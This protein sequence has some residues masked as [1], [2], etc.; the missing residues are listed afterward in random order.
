ML[1][2]DFSR[3]GRKRRISNLYNC[4]RKCIIFDATFRSSLKQKQVSGVFKIHPFNV[5]IRVFT[6]I[7]TKLSVTCCNEDIPRGA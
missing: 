1:V 2:R 4:L 3:N 5:R 7:M 6:G